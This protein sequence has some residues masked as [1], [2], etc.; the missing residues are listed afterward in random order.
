MDRRKMDSM[1][2]DVSKVDERENTEKWRVLED[3][4][5][6]IFTGG[7]VLPESGKIVPD[8]IEEGR[9]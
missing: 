6:Q 4:K 9:P 1:M 2:I 8:V 5:H 3:V 7:V